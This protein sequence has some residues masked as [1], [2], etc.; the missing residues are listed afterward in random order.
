MSLG[1]K[2]E[3]YSK[4][5]INLT[6]RDGS[7]F[8]NRV[9][10]K[11]ALRQ[12]ADYLKKSNLIKN[13]ANFLDIG[14]GNCYIKDL[15]QDFVKI[16]YLGVT[17]NNDEF[18]LARKNNIDIIFAD[19]HDLPV[20]ENSFDIVYASHILEHSVAPLVAL[21]EWRRVLKNGGHLILWGPIGRDFEGADN[22]TCV[23]G[24]RD[25]LLTLTYWQYRWLFKLAQFYIE[26]D[27]D[28]PYQIENDNQMR[29][30]N[31]AKKIEK[32]LNRFGLTKLPEKMPGSAHL[33][34]LTK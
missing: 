28:L 30:Y 12:L 32:F 8:S 1:E 13:N 21:L 9:G 4:Q 29:K 3:L 11:I 6:Q 7:N 22:G 34:I 33:F 19:M 15:L 31:V 17:I 5:I 27:F 18:K 16:K 23:Y 24:C 20:T 10:V 14:A 25:H 2:F 26:D